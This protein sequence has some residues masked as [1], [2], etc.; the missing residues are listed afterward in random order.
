MK[1]HTPRDQA[2][3]TGMA[4]V[5]IALLV[6]YFAEQPRMVVVAI[7]LLVVDMVWPA[8]YGPLAKIWF[9]L[10]HVLGTVVSKIILGAVYFLLVTPIGVVRGWLGAD[11]M[12]TKQWKSGTGSVF[13][14]R[15][16]EFAS[17]D[18]ERPY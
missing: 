14:V 7:G 10:G 5:L 17:Q 2:K 12:R 1:K 8:A 4:M 11:A 13:D 18:I 16:H 6:A 3:D 9:G 15:E